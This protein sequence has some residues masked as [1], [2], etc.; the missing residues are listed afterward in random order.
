MLFLFAYETQ[1]KYKLEKST[2]NKTN[3]CFVDVLLLLEKGLAFAVV[4]V[5]LVVVVVLII[6]V[7]VVL[8]VTPVILVT[9]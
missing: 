1:L 3:F 6:V 9:Y 2:K 5:L 4:A 7:E 8:T